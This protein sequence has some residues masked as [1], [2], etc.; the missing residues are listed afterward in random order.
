MTKTH[1]NYT[2]LMRTKKEQEI[3]AKIKLGYEHKVVAQIKTIVANFY[4]APLSVYATKSRKREIIMIKHTAIYLIYHFTTLP[5]T[6]IGAIFDNDHTTII[7][8]LNKMNNILETEELTRD[9]IDTLKADIRL[10][11]KNFIKESKFEEEMYFIDLNNCKSVKVG[12]GRYIVSVGMSDEE[13][14]EKYPEAE[15]KEHNNTHLYILE[16]NKPRK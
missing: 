6:S 5:L 4:N 12:E 13:L 16:N 2:N 9:I 7:A 1:F 11:L 10:N 14:L 15:I 3:L 8:S